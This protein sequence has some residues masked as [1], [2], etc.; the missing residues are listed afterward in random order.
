[1]RLPLKGSDYFC[2]KVNAS[3]EKVQQAYL[4]AV[5]P[6]VAMRKASVMLGDGTITQTDTFDP[7]RVRAFYQ[8]LAGLLGGVENNNAGSGGGWLFSGVSKS[9]TEDLH[10]LFCQFSKEVG[11]AVVATGVS[12]RQNKEK[13]EEKSNNN[14]SSRHSRYYHIS[15]YFGVQFHTLPYYRVDR[16]VVEIQKELA[17]IASKADAVFGKMVGKA[18]RAVQEELEKKGY[19]GLETQEL[20]TKMF[21]DEALVEQLDKKAA[22]VESQFP[23]F[24]EMRVQKNRLFGELNDMLV[25]LYQAAPVIIDYTRLMSGEEGLATYFDIEVI[26]NPGSKKSSREAFLDTAKMPREAADAIASELSFVADALRKAA[27]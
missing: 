3:A 18:D 7:Q 23:E 9:A 1:M 22:A 14:N 6:A 16:R 19:G 15:G 25:E 26:K 8:R 27:G 24:E 4:E 2:E 10:R 17:Q 5:G 11:V 13:E 12:K 20:F 21:E